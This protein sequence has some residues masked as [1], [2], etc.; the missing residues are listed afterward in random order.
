MSS[1]L[2]MLT[3]VNL[4]DLVSSFG[5]E[6][7]RLP[8]AILRRLFHGPAHKFAKQMVEYD[9]LV[10]RV[11]LQ[12]A[13]CAVLDRHYIHDLCIRGLENIPA[14]GP[15]LILSNHPG[16]TD[17]ISLFAAIPRSNLRVIALDRPFLAS[18][19]NISRH[20]VYISDDSGERIRAV[21]QV[22][23]H[24][25]AGGAALT[26]PAGKIE[27]DPDVH[28]GA[29]DSLKE[30]TRSS[31]VFM[32]FAQDLQIVPVL[33]SGVIWER[34]AH[35]WLTRFKHTRDDRERLSAALQLLAMVARD[36]RPTTVQVE[37]AK[38]ITCD[39]V[40]S[41]DPDCIHEK[42]MERMSYLIENRKK[43]SGARI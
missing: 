31:T 16:L 41:I 24:L 5:W 11:G 4:D 10:G 21:R 39:E 17:T 42:L 20:L 15:T 29:R 23:A 1:Q 13:S 12:E 6:N 37:F 38:P 9:E 27:P 8:A 18:L 14:S 25:R 33:V 34:T 3:K 43:E 19:P 26:F 22:A 2:D 40:G 35:H 36:A 28:P 7:S 32:R 30:W